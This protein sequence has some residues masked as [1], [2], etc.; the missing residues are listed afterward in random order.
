MPPAVR[1]CVKSLCVKSLP[2]AV[3]SSAPIRQPTQTCHSDTEHDQ[4]QPQ[5]QD[6]LQQSGSISG[7]G[8]NYPARLLW[9]PKPCVWVLVTTLGLFRTVDQTASHPYPRPEHTR[10]ALACW[11]PKVLS[12]AARCYQL[13]LM[14]AFVERERALSKWETGT[15]AIWHLWQ[16]LRVATEI[17]WS[18]QKN[19]EGRFKIRL[20]PGM[21]G[22]SAC[23]L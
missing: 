11:S 21:P 8:T 19:S 20:K 1:N 7:A 3:T 16:A 18:Q 4:H 2:H 15:L 10:S 12:P 13:S 23:L 22:W 5:L 14:R 9:K 17:W 6:G